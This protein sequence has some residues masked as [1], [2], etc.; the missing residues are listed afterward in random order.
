MKTR[1]KAYQQYVETLGKIVVCNTGTSGKSHARDSEK[2]ETLCGGDVFVANQGDEDL[3]LTEVSCK[4]C[5]NTAAF[6][7]GARGV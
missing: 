5:R 3:P 7:R 2:G 4:R 1:D 6:K